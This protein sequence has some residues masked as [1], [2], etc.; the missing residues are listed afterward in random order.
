MKNL[1]KKSYQNI[2]INTQIL[3]IFLVKSLLNLTAQDYIL[4]IDNLFIN[5]SLAK[6]LN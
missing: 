6:T 5:S 3:I 2:M 4:Y 1:D